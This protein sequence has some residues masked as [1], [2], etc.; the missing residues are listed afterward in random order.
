MFFFMAEGGGE[1]E[2]FI[3][4][5]GGYC[6]PLVV[7]AR[8]R[9]VRCECRLST[10]G[11]CFPASGGAY[12]SFVSCSVRQLR[13]RRSPMLPSCF[14]I[15]SVAWSCAVLCDR[16]VLGFIFAVALGAR[17]YVNGVARLCA[18]FRD[19]HFPR[20]SHGLFLL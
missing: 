5:G 3:I 15:I 20:C 18:A 1:G 2:G 6:K 17:F 12:G 11:V 8:L 10:C 4:G 9:A 7:R 16:R 14:Q 19:R 13:D